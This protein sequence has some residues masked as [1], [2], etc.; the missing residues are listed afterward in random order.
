MSLCRAKNLVLGT[1][2]CLA[3]SWAAAQDPYAPDTAE[4]GSVEAIRQYTTDPRFVSP[5]VAYV[6]ESAG[7]PSP[8]EVLG[9]IVGAP[10]E[11][12]HTAE[13]YRFFRELAR[14]SDRVHL[15][16]IGRTLEGRDILLVAVADEEGIRDL[17]RL[18]AVTAALADP[19]KTSPDK[20]EQMVRN[21]RPFYFINAALHADETGSVEMVMELAY[22]LAVSEQPMI[23]RIR[24]NVVVLINPVS[25]PD[26][27]D[28]MADWFYRFLKGK[29]DYDT[30]PRQSPPYWGRYVFVDANRDAHQLAFEETRAVHRMF[31][32]YHP[33][34]VHDLHEAIALLQTWNGTGPYN[35]HLDPIVTSAFLEMS[36]HEVTALTAL[37]MPGVW[38]WNFGEGFGHHFLDSVAMNH[39]SIGRGYETY[40]NAGAE[41][42]ER[43]LEEGAIT[44]EWYRPMPPSE[45]TLNWSMRDNVNYQET[46]LLAILDYTAKHATEMLHNFY[47]T[48]F[49]SWRKGVEEKPYAFVIPPDQ[50]DRRRVTQMVNRLMSQRIEVGRSTEAIRVQEGVFPKECYVVRLDQP[51]RNY[52]L[53]LLTPQEFPKDSENP[54]YDDISWA[55]PIHYGVEVERIDDEK[56]KTIPLEPLTEAVHA[57]GEVR[58][59]GPVFVLQDSGQEALLAARFRLSRFAVE[60]A[61]EPFVVGTTEYS[62]GSWILPAQEGLRPEL[63]KV[64]T[65]LALD[66]ASAPTMPD[67]VRHPAVVPRIGVWVPWADTDSIG[68][69]RYTLDQEAIPYTYLRDEEIRAGNLL[70]IVDVIVYGNVLLE[71]PGQIHGIERRHGPMP[72]TKTPEFP[73]HGVPVASE[74]ITGGIG[75]KGMGNL[76]E[77]LEAGGIFITLGRG[78]TLALESGLA[79][80]LRPSKVQGIFTPGAEL[81]ATFTQPNHP[82]AYGYPK[83]T[84]AF[85]SNYT[86]YDL[87]RR[88]LTMAYCTSCLDGPVN[89][90]PVVLQWGTGDGGDDGKAQSMVV[91]GGARG[92]E[93][94]EGLPAILDLAVGKGHLLAFNFNPLHRDLNHS[95]FRFLW[96][97]ILNWNA[98]TPAEAATAR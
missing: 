38:T 77:F 1:V 21:A 94:L 37:G 63:D 73:S 98:L 82:L 88:W 83:V 89:R 86:V 74:D 6:P 84:S 36:F 92:E 14:T 41:T 43:I 48:G 13:I 71:L 66:F 11:L 17:S 75:W 61:E 52:A 49:K 95:D 91:S 10:G 35:P 4:P 55:L 97:G 64:A 33:I 93:K 85:R 72:F 51:Y 44:R 26:G 5:W 34:V 19:R 56:I 62:R 15:E 76:Q 18:K 60:I 8:S 53:D 70:Q 79:R 40:G 65:E 24:E 46:A 28:K 42:L 78:T 22:R 67:V 25:N 23:R 32:D 58:G 27:R 9:H 29:T 59:Q 20:A 54:P 16:V 2:V 90:E 7:V 12:S 50:P 47:R 31:H 45:R 87:P 57:E 80:N 30:L 68:W 96:N 69:I 39:N 3:A 81:K